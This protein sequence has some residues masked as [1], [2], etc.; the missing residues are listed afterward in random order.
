MRDYSLF[1][2]TLR[3][4]VELPELTAAESTQPDWQLRS[5]PWPPPGSHGERLGTDVVNSSADVRL[6]RSDG[7]LR[8]VFDDTGCFEISPDARTIRWYHGPDVSLRDA[9]SDLTGRVFAAVLHVAGTLS[10]H[11]SAAVL[12]GIAVGV[13]A[14]KFHGKSTLTLALVKAGGRLLTDD[15][16]PVRPGDPPMAAPGL[17]AARLWSDSAERV[18]LGQVSAAGNGKQLFS[19]LPPDSLE[20]T[21]RPLGGIYLLSP[22]QALDD[23]SAVRRTRLSTMESA[24]VLIGHA[25]LGPLLKASEAPELFRRAVALAESVP[26]YRLSVVRDLDRLD[27]VVGAL[28]EWHAIPQ[29][30]SGGE[31]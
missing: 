12:D 28:F 1:G 4:E 29:V 18:G 3:S 20:D 30:V 2:G 24:M 11:G 27:E 9:R 17:H 31:R 7:G 22:T 26:V 25:K 23:G 15:T 10:L 5:L 6:Y 16:L 19:G 8:M 14:P 13:V 21:P